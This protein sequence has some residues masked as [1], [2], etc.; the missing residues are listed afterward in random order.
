[1]SS[2]SAA[3]ATRKRAKPAPG[4]GAAAGVG[5]RRRKVSRA[6]SRARPVSLVGQPSSRARAPTGAHS[7]AHSPIALFP[8]RVLGS[9]PLGQGQQALPFSVPGLLTK[10]G[11]CHFQ[12][13]PAGD[14]GK[15]KGGGKMNEE[16]SSDSESER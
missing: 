16:I 9:L 8:H 11:S 14:R 6:F 13:D 4:S 12:V 1:M 3:G 5:K 15:S 2:M 7:F 10:K